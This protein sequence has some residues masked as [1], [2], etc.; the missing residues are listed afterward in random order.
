MEKL[1]GTYPV[2]LEIPLAWGEM[3]SYEHINNIVY[4]R[5]FES[6][7]IHYFDKLDIK[8]LKEQTHIGPILAH[9]ECKYKIPLTYPDTVIACSRIAEVRDTDF[10]MEYAIFSQGHQKLAAEG[11]GRIVMINYENNQKV[12]IPEELRLLIR[13]VENQCSAE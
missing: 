7:R 1:V 12:A 5:Y 2:S 4:F 9:T 8:G 6:S 10:I 11:N 3:D 13:R